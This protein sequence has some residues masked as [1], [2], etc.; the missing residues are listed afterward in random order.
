MEDIFGGAAQLHDR[1]IEIAAGGLCVGG[2]RLKAR[3]GV[4][5]EVLPDAHVA[6]LGKHL[7]SASPSIWGVVLHQ[8]RAQRQPDEGP[9]DV[10]T[11][12]LGDLQR[13]V[14]FG[15]ARRRR[16]AVLRQILRSTCS[17]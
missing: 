9:R 10:V 8:H 3:D 7:E 17:R 13:L 4:Q 11:G 14:D 1:A 12:S 5:G 15:A 2:E 6:E 16:P